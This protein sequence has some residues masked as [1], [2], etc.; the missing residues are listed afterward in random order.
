MKLDVLSITKTITGK[1]ELPAQ[2]NELVRP[3]LIKRAVEAIQANRRQPYGAKPDA[4]MRASAEVSRRRRKYRGSY[5]HGI[6]RVPR[7]VMTRRGVQMYWVGAFAPGTVGGRRA[8]PPKQFKDSRKKINTKERRKATRSAITSTITR[9]LVEKRGH[10]LPKEYPFIIEDKIEGI[11]QTKKLLES[12]KKLG[13]EKELKRTSGSKIRAGRG[14]SR[15]RKYKT[16]KGPLLVVSRECPLLKTAANIPGLDAAEVQNLNAE[17]LAPGTQVG[18]MALFTEAAME[19]LAKEKLFTADYKGESKK[20]TKKEKEGK[21]KSE[22]NKK[23]MGPAEKKKPT[24]KKA[25]RGKAA[26][27]SKSDNKG[28]QSKKAQPT[29]SKKE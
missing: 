3:D 17:M 15:G 9:E 28:A 7:K 14:K 24:A 18:R 16:R 13:L 20:K 4:G 11:S 1:K 22:K 5:G 8:H 26:Q 10:Q 6:S 2:F 19:R 23:K 21:N 12:L 29:Q 25:G 27:K